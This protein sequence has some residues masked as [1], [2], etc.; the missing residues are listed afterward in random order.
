MKD[1]TMKNHLVVALT[2]AVLLSASL[3]VPSVRG[4]D[5]D[6]VM[7]QNGKMMMMKE[8]KAAGPMENSMTMSNGT[9]VMGDGTVKMKDGTEAHMK[10]GQMMMMDGHMME[11]GH[12]GSM[13]TGSTGGMNH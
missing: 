6:G 3:L 12:S 7:M 4:A 1:P 10:E 5:A 8:G 13:G 9:I 11:G 2:A